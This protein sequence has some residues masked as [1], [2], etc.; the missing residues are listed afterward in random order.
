[1]PADRSRPQKTSASCSLD[2]TVKT[3]VLSGSMSGG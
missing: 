3:T 2:T 1:M